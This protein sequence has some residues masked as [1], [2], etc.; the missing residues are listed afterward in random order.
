MNKFLIL[1]ILLTFS[2]GGYSQPTSGDGEKKKAENKTDAQ[3]RKQGLWAKRYPNNTVPQY[4]GEFKNDKPQG[5]FFFYYESGK[6]RAVIDY[7]NNGASAKAVMFHE[8]GE[9]MGQGN[10]VNEKKDSVWTYYDIKGL[11]S[12]RESYDNGEL[13]G[14]KIVYYTPDKRT[15]KERIAE[16]TQFKNGTPHGAWKQY[17]DTGQLKAEGNFVD[18]NY[19][20]AVT[21]YH[22]NGNKSK[23]RRYK[24]AVYHGWQR[25][26]DENGK[27]I[28]EKFYINN[29][30]LKGK[31]LE[32]YMENYKQEQ[33]KKMNK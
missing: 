19:D 30:Q 1:F 27:K 28:D 2:L 23:I 16:I 24:N 3:G 7:K 13:H 15:G 21:Y 22:P 26:F 25:V 17:F 33:L 9:I 4:V 20:G 32:A 12:M 8:T 31:E 11:I 5:R 18:G 29:K 6:V 10:Y 14:D